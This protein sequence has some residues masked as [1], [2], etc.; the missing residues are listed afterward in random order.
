MIILFSFFQNT[1]HNP[2]ILVYL[3]FF[4]FTYNLVLTVYGFGHP[5]GLL[6]FLAVKITDGVLPRERRNF[7]QLPILITR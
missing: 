1:H 3:F 4:F 7:N 5:C 6:L 2:S